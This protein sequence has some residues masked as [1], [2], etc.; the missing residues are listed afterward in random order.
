MNDH[1]RSLSISQNLHNLSD[2]IKGGLEG[3]EVNFNLS[4]NSKNSKFSPKVSYP[5]MSASNFHR[6]NE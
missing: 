1:K 3:T 6:L 4:P 2:F 5:E